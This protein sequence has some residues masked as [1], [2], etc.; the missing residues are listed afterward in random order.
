M[1]SSCLCRYGF[2][3]A[4]SECNPLL[5]PN[6]LIDFGLYQSPPADVYAMFTK[7]KIPA[8]PAWAWNLWTGLRPAS[9]SGLD[10]G[11]QRAKTQSAKSTQAAM[12]AAMTWHLT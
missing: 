12:A 4:V 7:I 9:A 11:L 6:T 8:D 1:A 3:P 10:G 2:T 5:T